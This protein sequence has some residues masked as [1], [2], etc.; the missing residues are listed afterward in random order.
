MYFDD[1]AYHQLVKKG[2]PLVYE[3]YELDTRTPGDIAFG[4]TV[5]YPG[6]VGREY[7][8]T[9][10]HFHEIL[11]TAEIYYCLSGQGYLLMENTKVTGPLVSWHPE[12]LYTYRRDMLI[13]V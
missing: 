6:K 7:F 3:F 4:T 10:G 13:E 2:D 9:K 11:D 1:E 8:M 12:R 5:I